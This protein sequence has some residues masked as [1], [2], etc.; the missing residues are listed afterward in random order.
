MK[1]TLGIV[2]STSLLISLMALPT[3]AAE[4][5]TPAPAEKLYHGF[6][7]ISNYR[8]SK[9]HLNLTTASV[10]F[11]EAGQIKSLNW[12]VMEITKT[13]FPG[14]PG[15]A[16]TTTP[17]PATVYTVVS[18]DTFAEIAIKNNLTVE[19]LTKLNPQVKDINWIYVGDK[20]V[21]KAAAAAAVAPATAAA[22][23]AAFQATVDFKWETKKEELD[24]Y[25]M[26]KAAVSG[27]EWWEQID[28]YEKLFTGKTVAEVEAWVNKYTDVNKRPFKLAYPEKLTNEADNKT[29]AAFTAEE[30]AMLVDVTTGA[31]MSLEDDHS[32]FISA[33]KEAYAGKEEIK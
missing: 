24:T 26:K 28:S 23:K 9:D 15:A 1:K 8:A 16:P 2:L 19:A 18:G 11:N 7:E 33:L 29:I 20:I 27:K 22:D 17:A 30:K 5:T 10:V 14:W 12:D 6:G 21:V 3:F 25:G 32:K 13:L 31:T 4:G